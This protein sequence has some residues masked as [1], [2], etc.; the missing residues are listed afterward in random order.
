MQVKT[1]NVSGHTADSKPVKLE[2]NGTVLLPPL[3]FPALRQPSRAVF[4]VSNLRKN[5]SVHS[6]LFL[7]F[8]MPGSKCSGAVVTTLH[9]LRNFRMDPISYSVTLH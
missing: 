2:V 7:N 3:V 9:F 1:K 6:L 8:D 4:V 5:Y